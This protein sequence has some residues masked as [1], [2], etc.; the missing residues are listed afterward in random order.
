MT[1]YKKQFES[2]QDSGSETALMEF[3]KADGNTLRLIIGEEELPFELKIVDGSNYVNDFSWI[4]FNVL[5]Q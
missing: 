5:H 3:K 2:W 4:F 1:D